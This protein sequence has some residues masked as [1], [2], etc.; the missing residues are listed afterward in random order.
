MGY[1]K[2]VIPFGRASYMSRARGNAHLMPFSSTRHGST[3]TA[4]DLRVT[5]ACDSNKLFTDDDTNFLDATI[6][7]LTT[8]SLLPSLEGLI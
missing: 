6:L 5:K 2:H 4:I 3:A 7:A 1:G 8:R